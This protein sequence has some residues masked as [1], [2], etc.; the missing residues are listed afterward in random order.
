MS[1]S[2]DPFLDLIQLLRPR[3][4][5]WSRI[6]AAGQWAISFRKRDDLLFCRVV[7]G[8]CLLL[9]P[10]MAAVKLERDDF[11]LIRTSTPFTLASDRRA[12]AIDSEALVAA[13]KSVLLRVGARGRPDTILRGGKFVFDTANEHLLTGLMP[14]VLRVHAGD[15]SSARVRALLEMNERESEQPGPGSAFVVSR[16]ME[17]VLLEMLRGQKAGVDVRQAGLLAGLEDAS[18]ARALELMHGAV[19][20]AWTVEE[21]ARRCGMSRSAF[22]ARF[23]ERVGCGPIEYLL[24]WRMALAKDALREG[25]QSVGEIALAVGFQSSSAFSTSFRRAVGVSPRGYVSRRALS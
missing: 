10:R 3:A 1:I 17:L 22:A 18:S 6:D 19:A 14:Q 23:R 11:V 21:L 12:K 5:L 25:R 16:L 24:D 2:I 20:H 7:K 13:T 9:R 8:G 15:T 4:T